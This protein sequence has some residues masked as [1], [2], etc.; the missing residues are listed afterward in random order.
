MRPSELIHSTSFRLGLL[1]ASA[2]AISVTVLF[3]VVYWTTD[4]A[5]NRQIDRDIEAESAAL[6]SKAQTEGREGLERALAERARARPDVYYLLRDRMGH[7]LAGNLP[8]QPVALGWIDAYRTIDQVSKRP[9]DRAHVVHAK[10]VLIADGGLLF[11]GRDT[12]SFN[13]LR[14]AIVRGFGICLIFTVALALGSSALMSASVLRRIAAINRA[15]REIMSGEL[16]RRLPTTDR[17]DEFDDLAA[18]LNTM[19]DRIHTLMENLRQVSTDIAHDLRT[20]L[21]RLRQN[22]ERARIQGRGRPDYEAAIDRAIAEIDDLLATFSSLLRIA[23]IEAGSRRSGFTKVQLSG[24]L[25]NIVE[26]FGAVAEDR[27]QLLCGSIEHDVA[28]LGDRELLTQMFANLVENALRHT[29]AGSTISIDL[30]R[31]EGIPLAS[32][33]D[34]GPG[35]PAHMR[36]SV[37]KRFVRLDGSRGTPGNGLGLSL[38]AAVAELHDIALELGDNG[39]GLRVT[40]RFPPPP[41]ALCSS[42]REAP[43]SPD[44]ALQ[45]S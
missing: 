14:E 16:A 4:L 28:V 21:G 41:R 22:L 2:F 27:G 18:R 7:R 40:L 9:R 44:T 29:G 45:A 20:P 13:E 34:D 33:A 24:L 5:L 32:V 3:L 26:V 11:V 12:Y 25:E 37:L 38:V 23:Q 35:I 10:G 36:Q 8:N 42:L 30:R 1:H 15:T 6:V 31:D 19:L 39:P 43:A 17:K